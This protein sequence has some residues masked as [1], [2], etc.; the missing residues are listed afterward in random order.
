ML[1]VKWWPFNWC[2][3][4]TYIWVNI[5]SC[6]GLLPDATKKLPEPMLANHQWGLAAFT[7]GQFHRKCSWYLCLIWVWVSLNS[8]LQ[9]AC[10]RDQRVTVCP[11]S[12]GSAG[13]PSGRDCGRRTKTWWGWACGEDGPSAAAASGS[14]TCVSG[15]DGHIL[16]QHQAQMGGCMAPSV[17]SQTV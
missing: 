9:P 15:E 7:W 12:P 8:K 13:W 2:R 16:Q 17:M 11:L 3:M 1:S 14:G 5:G 4:V 10:P 6:N